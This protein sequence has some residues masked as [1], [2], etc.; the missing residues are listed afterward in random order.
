M[1]GGFALWANPSSPHAEGRRAKQA[2]EDAR[3]RIKA[4][5]GWDGEAIFTAT[6]SE[7][8]AIAIGQGKRPLTCA[9]AI[10]HDAVLRFA[11]PAQAWPV[12][13]GSALLAEPPEGSLDGLVAVQHAN[14]EV[15]VIQDAAAIRSAVDAGGGWWLADCAQTAGKLA[16]PPCDMAIVAAHKLGGP[17]GAAALLVRDYAMLEASGGHERGYRR[18]TENLPAILGMAAALEADRGWL[19][20]ALALR[21]WLDAQ[22]AA[23]GGEVVAAHAPR[24]ATIAS[25]RLPGMSATAQL[26]RLDGAGIAVSA[27]SACSSGTLR[28]SHVLSAM[29]HPH[30]GEVIR[31]SFGWSTTRADVERFVQ[32]WVGLAA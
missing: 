6:A 2:L 26:I 12:Q 9:S 28:D 13:P 7:A 10:E 3:A 24:L 14:S 11:G 17:I 16:L 25:Y 29:G 15:G 32:A 30:P 27:G 8:A 18:G 23:H 5:L 21:E 20:E 31:V 1:E 19:D 4:A 22:I